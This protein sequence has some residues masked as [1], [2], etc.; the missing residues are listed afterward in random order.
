MNS[1][2]N[3]CL[4]IRIYAVKKWLRFFGDCENGMG[5]AEALHSYFFIAQYELPSLQPPSHAKNRS[6]SP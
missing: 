5:S 4:K 3:D 1:F 2:L 6:E